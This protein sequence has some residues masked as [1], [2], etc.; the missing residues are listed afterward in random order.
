[1]VCHLLIA[2]EFAL[3]QVLRMDIGEQLLK[4][5]WVFDLIALLQFVNLFHLLSLLEKL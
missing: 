5:L 1:M 2:V 3:H 4:H